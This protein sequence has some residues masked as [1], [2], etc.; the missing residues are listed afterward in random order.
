M[1]FSMESLLLNYK[2]LVLLP[3]MQISQVRVNLG[4]MSAKVS[5][6]RYRESKIIMIIKDSFFLNI[7]LIYII[8]NFYVNYLKFLI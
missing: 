6:N 5:I 2:V 8:F 7:L 4:M 1:V 3:L